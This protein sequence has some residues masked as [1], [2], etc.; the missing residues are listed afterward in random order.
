VPLPT[1]WRPPR[2]VDKHL[3][4]LDS[5]IDVHDRLNAVPVAQKLRLLSDAR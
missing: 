5:E 3:E 1:T 4:R 2:T